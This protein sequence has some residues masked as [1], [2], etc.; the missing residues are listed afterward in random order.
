M[1]AR[2]MSTN[3]IKTILLQNELKDIKKM[4]LGEQ[5]QMRMRNRKALK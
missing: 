5:E 4:I 1:D 3:G 2:K